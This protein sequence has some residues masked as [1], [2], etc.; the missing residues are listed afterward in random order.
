MNATTE[1]MYNLV[2]RTGISLTAFQDWFNKA[3]ELSCK[4]DYR[5]GLMTGREEGYELGYADCV[6]NYGLK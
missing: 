4:E 3:V 2:Q 6:D 1:E 5:E